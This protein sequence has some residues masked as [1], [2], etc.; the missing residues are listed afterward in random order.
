MPR[1]DGQPTGPTSPTQPGERPDGSDDRIVLLG[2]M[3]AGKTTIGA[4]L[5]ERL[6]WPYLDN[7]EAVRAMTGREPAEIGDTEGEDALHRLESAA[8]GWALGGPPPMIV[9]AAGGIADDPRA[10]QLLGGDTT[11]VWLRATPETLQA[12]IGGGH[13]RRVEATDLD[14]ITQRAMERQPRYGALADL[15]IDVDRLTPEEIASAIT[16]SLDT[17]SKQG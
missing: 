3:G 2:M 5:S 16:A 14:W 12:R 15:V 13:G 9:G 4:L 7:D 11:V 8:L 1:S 10:S 6:G 17:S